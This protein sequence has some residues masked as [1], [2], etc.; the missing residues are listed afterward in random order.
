M[1]YLK[2]LFVN[3]LAIFFA[4]YLLPG[5]AVCNQ[6]KL[7]H[8][9]DDLPFALVLSALN[10]AIY[11][12]LK[13]FPRPLFW[14]VVVVSLFLNMMS[15]ALLRF[16]IKGIE[17]QSFKGFLF[18]ALWVWGASCLTLFFFIARSLKGP[19]PSSEEGMN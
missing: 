19:P 10:L 12:I 6:T 15:Y 16:F 3:F 4:N 1:N 9:G 7:P 14:K 2:A 17:I 8:L 13:M 18:P 5:I 11:P